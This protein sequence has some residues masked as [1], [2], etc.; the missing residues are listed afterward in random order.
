MPGPQLAWFKRHRVL[1]EILMHASVLFFIAIALEVILRL[2]ISYNPGYYVSINKTNSEA[3][4]PWGKVPIN[5]DGYPDK[6]FKISDKPRVGYFGDSVTYGVGAGYGNRISEFLEKAYPAYDHWNFGGIGAA[7]SR[8]RIA[9]YAETAKTF[10]LS[11]VVYLFNLN[12]IIPDASET[13]VTKV[14]KIQD[15]V[16]SHLDWFRSRSYLYNYCRTRVKNYLASQGF[17]ASGQ[18]AAEL[19]PKKHLEVVEQTAKRINLMNRTMAQLGVRFH[20]VLLPYEMQISDDAARVYRELHITW[21]EGFLDGSPQRLLSQFIDKDVRVYNTYFAFVDPGAE[22]ESKAKIK[23]GEYYVYNRGDKMDWN[24][25]LPVAQRIIS[26]Y[27]VKN[28][29][30]D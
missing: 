8:E 20:L 9:L 16:R 2:Q 30:L 4:Y 29:I 24:H 19:Y 10:K 17:E 14:T 23:V 21:E 18:I 11:H 28:G 3:E 26:D 5:S 6:E 1:T 22:S 27:L 12:D 13:K 15:F 25:P 7:M